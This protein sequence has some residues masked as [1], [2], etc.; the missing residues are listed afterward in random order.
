MFKI[1]KSD[2]Y[3]QALIAKI[4]KAQSRI[5]IQA[6]AIEFTED[7]SSII[8]ELIN[9]K[10]K[11]VDVRINIDWYSRMY[12]SSHINKYPL[13]LKTRK[14]MIEKVK[15]ENN[16]YIQKLLDADIQ[17]IYINKPKYK[18]SEYIPYIGR[19]HMK[20]ILIDDCVFIGGMNI[21]Q[22]S[23]KNVDFMAESNNLMLK[24]TILKIFT[25]N[26]TLYNNSEIPISSD[27]SLLVDVGTFGNSIIYK[28]A[29]ESIKSSK[30]SI[31]Y[32]SQFLPNFDI[33]KALN[34]AAKRSVDV[35]IITYDKRL[36]SQ[37]F[38]NKI[39]HLLFALSKKNL[40]VMYNKDR[41]VHAKLLLIDENDNG[42]ALFGSHNFSPFGV[43]F[44][45][46]EIA[47]ST[48]NK[49]CIDD[50]NNWYASIKDNISRY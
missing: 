1:V 46:A 3:K 28:K 13:L 18:I 47:I 36:A 45:T 6:M 4:K 22:R 34:E 35:S 16:T 39:D 21:S 7:I 31:R 41:Y 23:F 26:H 8:D 42:T 50:L 43:Y 30:S 5:Y 32:I 27:S 14:N 37:K 2:T 10:K 19:N 9:A 20:F 17:I 24:D 12:T 11:G 48:K 25:N 44:K 15:K 49:E 33:L 38:A 29:L 40:S